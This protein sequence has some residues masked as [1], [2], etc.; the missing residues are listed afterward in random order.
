M[1]TWS[2]LIIIAAFLWA[3]DGLLR[4]SLYSLPSPTLIFFEHIVWLLLIAPFAY[5]SF[6]KAVFH[7]KDTIAFFTISLLSWVIGTLFFTMA[8]A[9]VG[10][11]PMSVA[12]LIQK[13]QPIFAI[14][15]AILVRHEKIP[16]WSYFYI[17]VALIAGYFV[18]FPHWV[19]LTP[20]WQKEITAAL[21]ALIAAAAWGS[22]TNISK[23]LLSRY[24]PEVTT[25]V[26]FVLTSLI[27]A[28][29]LFII[30]SWR[31]GFT[32]PNSTQWWYLFAIALS[33]W[34]VAMYIYYRGLRSTPVHVSA[35]LELTWP[36]IAVWVDYFMYGT[37][38]TF[39]QYIAIAVLMASMYMVSSL[40]KKSSPLPTD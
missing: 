7:K 39:E 4:R 23:Y 25:F 9:A 15:V 38:F 16:K 2:L 29:G 30:P 17:V 6:R 20:E 27:I 14:W 28:L 31:E 3:V 33:T 19:S 13:L 36:I 32:L 8:L 12:I 22:S 21:Y 37:I 35:I 11:I 10:Y 18:T 40:S 26:R 1:P 34:L 24:Q 5:S